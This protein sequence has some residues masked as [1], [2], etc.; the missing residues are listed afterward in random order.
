MGRLGTPAD[1]G[2]AVALLCSEEAGLDYR[3]TDRRRWR[4]GIDGCCPPSG[5]STGGPPVGSNPMRLIAFG[6]LAIKSGDSHFQR[7]C[8]RVRY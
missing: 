2:N 3:P 4:G 6:L 8:D 1:I 5:D 7:Q